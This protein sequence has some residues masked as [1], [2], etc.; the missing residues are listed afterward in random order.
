M[1]V[2]E[3][4][5]LLKYMYMYTSDFVRLRVYMMYSSYCS[6]LQI[7]VFLLVHSKLVTLLYAHYTLLTTCINLL[8]PFPV[9]IVHTCICM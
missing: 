9:Y 6:V 5:A 2:Y 3:Y 8:S 1:L 7:G 4:I